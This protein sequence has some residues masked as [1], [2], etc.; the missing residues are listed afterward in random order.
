MRMGSV[1]SFTMKNFVVCA[2]I[3]S[4]KLKLSGHV[5]KVGEDRNAFKHVNK[6]TF[7]KETYRKP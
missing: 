6:E 5:A 2:S 4:R 7:S 1:E 3:K